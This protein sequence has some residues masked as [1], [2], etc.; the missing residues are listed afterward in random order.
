M[1]PLATS[2]RN[3]EGLR[4][5]PGKRWEIGSLALSSSSGHCLSRS[6][7]CSINGLHF[8]S[9][10]PH[11]NDL[12][13]WPSISAANAFLSDSVK[14]ISFQKAYTNPI[15]LPPF[16]QIAVATSAIYYIIRMPKRRTI[17]AKCQ[18]VLIIPAF[19]SSWSP[20]AACNIAFLQFKSVH[21]IHWG[22]TWSV[23]QWA[24][25]HVLKYSTASNPPKFGIELW[26]NEETQTMSP[27]HCI[28]LCSISAS[29]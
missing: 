16:P 4:H 3:W 11:K 27:D 14:G 12:H 19:I 7:W 21:S 2:S 10:L 26:P 18:C 24:M 22:M 29:G 5:L 15:C 1:W 13:S 6:C 28:A 9:R 23:P 20:W 25:N 17:Q 8:F